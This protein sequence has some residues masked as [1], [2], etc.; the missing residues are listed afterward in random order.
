MADGTSSW[1]EI[2]EGDIPFI[3]SFPHTGTDIPDGF[4]DG[5]VSAALALRDTDW[6][7][8]KVFR[9]VLPDGATV[10]RTSISRSVIDM[11]RPPE[12]QSLYPGQAT[13]G[14][15]PDTDFDGAPLYRKGRAPDEAEVR[16]RRE[17][18]HDRYSRA[19]RDQI[20]RLLGIHGKVAVLD[21]H[22]IR[23]RVPRLFE[24]TL[25]ALN[26]GTNDGLSCAPALQ[27]RLEELAE[28][29]PFSW[30][31]NGRFKGGWITRHFGA[32]ARGVHCV[33]IEI[34]M[35]AYL[36]VADDAEYGAPAYRPEAAKLLQDLLRTFVGEMARI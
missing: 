12:G 36:T 35:N 33:Q 2:H 15:C 30:V 21:C 23:P 22:S 32:P 11:N 9:P 25:P 29:S 31:S 17:L 1:L 27:S 34:T 28:A 3:A 4:A 13:T 7:L 8:E 18:Y 6:H 14:L 16:R 24:G 19:L 10:V 5:F 26:I 20:E